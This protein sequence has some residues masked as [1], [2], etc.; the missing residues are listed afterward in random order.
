MTIVGTLSI[1]TWSVTEP[2]ISNTSRIRTNRMP[3]IRSRF[4]QNIIINITVMV[5]L[6]SVILTMIITQDLN[7][8]GESDRFRAEM[9][10]AD[11]FQTPDRRVPFRC[12]VLRK[13]VAVCSTIRMHMT[14]GSATGVT[15]DSRAGCRRTSPWTGRVPDSQRTS[16]PWPSCC[17]STP[18]I[19]CRRGCRCTR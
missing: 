18:P 2:D 9:S 14:R 6:L 10:D 8:L 17:G 13:D 4:D 12:C 19:R 11:T 5:I 15:P 7:G 16:P 3:S 1:R